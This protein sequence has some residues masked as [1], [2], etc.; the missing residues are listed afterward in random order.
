[1]AETKKKS[2]FERGSAIDVSSYLFTKNNMKY[3]AWSRAEELLKLT[4]PDA[5][6]TEV[7]FPTDKYISVPTEEN[8]DGKCYEVCKTTVEMPYFTDGKTCMVKTRV[9]IPSEGV[10]QECTLPIMD[11]KN[12]PIS[13][14][15]V[16]MTDV[17]KSLKRCMT[18]NIAELTGI[19][20]GLW[21]KEEQSE[22]AIAQNIISKLD[23]QDAIGKFKQKIA[24]GFDRDKLATWLKANFGTNNPMTI[25]SD[26]V[27]DRL[28]EELDKLDIKEFKKE[29]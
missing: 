17:N 12:Q 21:H 2:V 9:E 25:K 6:I 4:F 23:R 15:K 5:V 14:E 16:T 27:L 11:F 8:K 1:M 18:K 19:G 20:L 10:S 13:A 22:T 28:N 24:D 29:K 7:T 3:L 26:E